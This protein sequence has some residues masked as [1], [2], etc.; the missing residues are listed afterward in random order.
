MS[1]LTKAVSENPN[2]RNE[3]ALEKRFIGWLLWLSML[4]L[5]I[6]LFAPILTM[7]KFT[8]IKNEVSIYTSLSKLF[9]DGRYGLF[10]IIL[11]VSVCFPLSKIFSLAFVWYGHSSASRK[12]KTPLRRI[13]ASSRWS[14]LDVFGVTLL[15]VT[16]KLGIIAGVETHV[17]VYFFGSAVLGIMA[18]SLLMNRGFHSMHYSLWAIISSS[19]SRRRTSNVSKMPGTRLMALIRFCYSA[20]TIERIF[21]P[22]Y[23]D[24][25]E[26][27]FAA[28]AAGKKWHAPWIRVRYYKDFVKAVGLFGIVRL[29]KTMF[30]YWEKTA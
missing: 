24:F 13:D 4:L 11:L 21:D 5:I 9:E 18:A 22:I 23:A 17:G 3:P 20:K 15:V 19:D 29:A 8:V 16:I 7:T 1:D 12:R 2:S 30:E 10:S 14:M 6:G 25:Y 26:E 28:L 27:Y